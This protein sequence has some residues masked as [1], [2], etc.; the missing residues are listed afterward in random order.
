MRYS[1]F[2]ILTL[3]YFGVHLH[4]EQFSILVWSLKV[5]IKASGDLQDFAL[6]GNSTL[7]QA[8]FSIHTWPVWLVWRTPIT[9]QS[10]TCVT[11]DISLSAL[12]YGHHISISI[13]FSPWT[14]FRCRLHNIILSHT[15]T[16]PGLWY[17]AGLISLHPGCSIC[18]S[19]CY[20]CNQ[21]S[22]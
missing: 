19:I 21:N 13:T 18:L 11:T 7:D 1:T 14:H 12:Y 2:N 6:G 10:Q 16:L 5:K 9:W 15:I 22:L 20:W 4:L 8:M 3:T 17:L